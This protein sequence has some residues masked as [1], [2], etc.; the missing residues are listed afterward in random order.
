MTVTKKLVLWSCVPFADSVV[1]L[2]VTVSGRVLGD[3]ILVGNCITSYRLVVLYCNLQKDVANGGI[4][5]DS[6]AFLSLFI[7]FRTL[8]RPQSVRLRH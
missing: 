1:W 4:Q 3:V 6:E 5:D 2:H 7:M 8:K